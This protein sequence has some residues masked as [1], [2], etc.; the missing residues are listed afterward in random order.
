MG[1]IYLFSGPCGCGKTT[2]AKAYSK[3]LVNKNNRKQVYLIHGDDF[4]AGFVESDV[5][6]K[7]HTDNLSSN[8][9]NWTAILKFNWECI[10]NVA[11]NVLKN[12]LDVVIDYVVEEELCLV[13][14]LA[15]E[16]NA[17]LYYVVLTA[18][19]DAIQQRIRE[20][21]DI[22]LLERALYLKNKLDNLPENQ[23]HLFDN[24]GMSISDE[25]NRLEIEKFVLEN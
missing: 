8:Y 6:E 15:K 9:L 10:I 2:L 17:K 5:K 1:D 25:I 3:Y 19:N 23:I 16:Y 18:S 14:Q 20:R 21:G 7:I 4:H 24:T 13:Q 11:K 12:G 22:D